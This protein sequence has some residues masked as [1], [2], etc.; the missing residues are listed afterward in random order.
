MAEYGLDE[1]ILDEVIVEL[2]LYYR[3]R[4]LVLSKET[5]PIS[6]E[7]MSTCNIQDKDVTDIEIHNSTL[8]VLLGDNFDKIISDYYLSRFNDWDGDNESRYDYC[9][10]NRGLFLGKYKNHG[11]KEKYAEIKKNMNE[12]ETLFDI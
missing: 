10:I 11:L 1:G 12:L 3:D 4:F 6:R 9:R 8:L 5:S 7:L 2:E